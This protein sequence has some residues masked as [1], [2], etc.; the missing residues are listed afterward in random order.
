MYITKK[1]LGRYALF[2]TF[3]E[4]KGSV[5]RLEKGLRYFFCFNS[6]ISAVDLSPLKTILK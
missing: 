1:E 3:A 4:A 2:F 5:F 6:F